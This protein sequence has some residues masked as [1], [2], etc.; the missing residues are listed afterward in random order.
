MKG[1][2][3]A[4]QREQMALAGDCK[5]M[6]WLPMLVVSAPDPVS[7]CSG[8]GGGARGSSSTLHATGGRFCGLFR[9]SLHSCTVGLMLLAAPSTGLFCGC[10]A[11]SG[12]QFRL[13]FLVAP[14]LG[15]HGWKGP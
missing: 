8:P 9:V 2:F 13:G 15:F 14:F 10:R 4:K 5:W 6:P 3:Q 7:T 11:L 1:V 12:T